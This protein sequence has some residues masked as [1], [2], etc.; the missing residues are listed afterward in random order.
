MSPSPRPSCGIHSADLQRHFTVRT[1]SARSTRPLKRPGSGSRSP[2]T[3]RRQARPRD[4]VDR[5]FLVA[6]QV[7]HVADPAIRFADVGRPSPHPE[8]AVVALEGLIFDITRHEFVAVIGAS[9]CGKSTLLRLIAGLSRRTAGR[10]E[11]YGQPV[12]GPRDEI[13]IVFQQPTLLPWLDVLGNVTFPMR[14]KHGRVSEDERG[15]GKAAA[16]RSSASRTSR[17]GAR[18]SCRA[19]CSSASRSRARCCYDPDILLMDEPFS[20]LDALTRDEM[21]F[22]CCASGRDGRRPSCSSP[23]RSPKRCCSPTGSSS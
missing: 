15:A 2:R 9:G 12:A 13:G 4:A 19:A 23:T 6:A 20:A 10:V 11:I 21:S 22:D 14:H 5:G 1:A 18:T 17:N 8:G 3:G 7:R 16:R